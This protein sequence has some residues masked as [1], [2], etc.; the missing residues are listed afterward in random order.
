MSSD[1]HHPRFDN[2]RGYFSAVLERV[3][4]NGWAPADFQGM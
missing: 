2:G 4:I 3:T 1:G